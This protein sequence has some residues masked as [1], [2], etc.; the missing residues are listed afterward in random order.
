M[1]SHNRTFSKETINYFISN[2]LSYYYDR[3]SSIRKIISTLIN[4]FI[5]NYGIEEWP[6]LFNIICDNL[7]K[8]DRIEKTSQTLNII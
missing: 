8:E 7:D 3:D 5:S 2:I 1:S 6:Q 4:C